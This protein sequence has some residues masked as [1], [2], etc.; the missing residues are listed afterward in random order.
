MDQSES[1]IPSVKGNVPLMAEESPLTPNEGND[2]KIT[3]RIVESIEKKKSV[4]PVK[5][6]QSKTQKLSSTSSFEQESQQVYISHLLAENEDLKRKLED[7]EKELCSLRKN[8]CEGKSSADVPQL[9]IDISIT[10]TSSDDNSSSEKEGLSWQWAKTW[11]GFG[12]T[13]HTPE[14]VQDQ[15]QLL[16][17]RHTRLPK[18]THASSKQTTKVLAYAQS[19]PSTASTKSK[20]SDLS[21]SDNESTTEDEEVGYLVERDDDNFRYEAEEGTRGVPDAENSNS[22]EPF[23]E[24]LIER[25][26]WLVG[27]LVL[28]SLSG[29][30]LQKNE[31]LLQEHTVIVN[32]LT[33][34]VGAGGNAGNQ[35]S[36][37]V[38]RGLAVGSLNSNT[39]SNFLRREGLMALCLSFILGLTGFIRAAVFST[40]PAE[41]VAITVSLVSIVAISIGLGS[42]LPLVM[43]KIR[44]DPA[45]SSTTIQVVM[46]ILGVSI[47]CWV[48]SL[49]LKDGFTRSYES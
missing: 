21:M 39:Q 26:S 14:N 9:D 38:I 4:T 49:I 22:D 43:N 17:H 40:P 7:M 48:C 24:L 32:F 3:T 41:T 46:D 1:L 29:F 16:K 42:T 19:V 20:N 47:T 8:R 44:I 2:H 35:A 13:A 45:H 34:L 5:R 11:T 30:I 36:V 33:M 23:K 27:L 28:Q 10:S 37:R 25:S 6:K 15:K 12:G 31:K 18:S